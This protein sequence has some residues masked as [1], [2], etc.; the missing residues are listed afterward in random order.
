VHT[1]APAVPVFGLDLILE[2]NGEYDQKEKIAG[3]VNANSGGIVYLSP[4]IRATYGQ[5][6]A[7]ASVG[8]PIVN[9]MNGLQSEPDYRVVGGVAA[10][11]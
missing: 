3:V 2:L 6:S 9:E 4:G 11:F 1:H 8:I 5:F 7:F 10:S